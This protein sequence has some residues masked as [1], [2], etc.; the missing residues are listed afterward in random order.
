MTHVLS[1]LCICIPHITCNKLTKPVENITNRVG[2]FTRSNSTL[3]VNCD[4]YI[5]N[6]RCFTIQ[7]ILTDFL[8]GVI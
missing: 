8:L 3:L 5:S 1:Y 2:Y 6:F 4:N 7:Y